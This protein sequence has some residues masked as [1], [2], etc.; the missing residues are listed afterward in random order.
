MQEQLKKHWLF[1]LTTIVVGTAGVT[2]TVADQ[3]L[4]KPRDFELSRLEALGKG[5]TAPAPL[6]TPTGDPKKTVALVRAAVVFLDTYAQHKAYR[7]QDQE[8]GTSNAHFLVS[9]IAKDKSLREVMQADPVIT[10]QSGTLDLSQVRQLKPHV[11][12]VHRSAF[13]TAK[14]SDKGDVK[15][16]EFLRSASDTDAL[17]LVYS[18]KSTTNGALAKRLEADTGLGGRIFVYEFPLGDPFGDDSQVRHFLN[19]VATLGKARLYEIARGER[20]VR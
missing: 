20:S 11:I 15:L 1:G 8:T 7:K 12:V 2:W 17:F 19:N 5:S 3:I 14:A 18:R 13:D 4:V 16:T 9:T 6:P 10:P